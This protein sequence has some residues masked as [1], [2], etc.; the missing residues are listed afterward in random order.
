MEVIFMAARILRDRWEG[1]YRR[2]AMAGT[3]D[4]RMAERRVGVERRKDSLHALGGSGGRGIAEMLDPEG[5][6]AYWRENYQSQPHYE[7]GYT[8]DD[9]H[10]A[11]RAGWE[12]RARYEGRDFDAVERELRADYE[13]RRGASRLDWER[14]R[15][16]AR[17]AWDR[18]DATDDFERSQ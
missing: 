3:P 16:A 7:A 13:R 2:N 15:K 17:A 14:C 5:E 10:P 12:G 6:E 9:Y 18:F 4:R 11:Y 8:Y 1:I